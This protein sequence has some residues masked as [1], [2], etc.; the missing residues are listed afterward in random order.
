MEITRLE[1]NIIEVLKE[2]QL[3]LG[4]RSEV[5]RLYYPLA[6]LN[7]FL[8]QTDTVEEMKRDLQEFCEGVKEKLGEVEISNQGER[9][10]IKIPEQGVN[11]VHEH[12]SDTEF[13]S[14]FIRTIEK[15][16][17][18][19]EDLMEQFQKHS[20]H[21]HMEKVDHG[22]FDYLVYFEDGVPDN[23]R[24]CIT[25]EGRHMMYHRFTE[26]DYKDFQFER[27]L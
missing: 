13:I 12:M 14:D 10:C 16:S 24:Y 11:Y 26:A 4:Y 1:E 6:S 18:T 2:Q 25:D 17:C 21:V 15:H 22:E 9:F 19:I 23:F 20:D 27:P 3:K 7:S 5:I 8:L